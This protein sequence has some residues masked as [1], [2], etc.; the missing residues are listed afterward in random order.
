MTQDIAAA[1]AR[2]QQAAA[3][4]GDARRGMGALVPA[5]DAGGGRA[6]MRSMPGGCQGGR[7]AAHGPAADAPCTCAGAGCLARSTRRTLC[8]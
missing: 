7:R 5:G 2:A 3:A 8:P 1:Q 4:V 6:Q